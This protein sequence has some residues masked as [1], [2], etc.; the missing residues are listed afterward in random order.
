MRQQFY[1]PL[2]HIPALSYLYVVYI[3]FSLWTNPK[4]DEAETIYTYC[5]L[6]GF[7]FFL[8]HS[9]FMM[10]PFVRKKYLLLGFLSFYGLIA[11]G[12]NSLIPNN[13]I[14]FTYLFIILGR[15]SV[16][17]DATPGALNK[18]SVLAVCRALLFLFSVFI[19]CINAEKIP[20]E[21]ITNEFLLQSDYESVKKVGGI[22]TDTPHVGLCFGVVYFCGLA[23]IDLA[24]IYLFK[25]RKELTVV[26]GKKTK[27][28]S[29]VFSK[30][31]QK[32]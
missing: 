11:W 9:G 2:Y 22:F 32:S 5:M 28:Q 12:L 19:V 29:H 20:V 3:Y 6:M 16:A 10:L 13:T 1:K 21:G 31:L 7:E 26:N 8:V 4:L 27:N 23:I 17:F 18:V 24:S 14:L 25:E 30:G 15:M